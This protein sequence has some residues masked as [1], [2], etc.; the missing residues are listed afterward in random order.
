VRKE[1]EKYRK[2]AHRTTD[3]NAK[4]SWLKHALEWERLAQQL[5]HSADDD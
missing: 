1:A 5:D 3:K 4:T 2:M